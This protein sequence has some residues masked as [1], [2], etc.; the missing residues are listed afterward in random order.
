MPSIQP[1]VHPKTSGELTAS[2]CLHGIATALAIRLA[3]EI[4]YKAALYAAALT[5]LSLSLI[6]RRWVVEDSPPPPPPPTLPTITPVDLA[7]LDRF[8]KE[9]QPHTKPT[10]QK[11]PGEELAKLFAEMKG[12]SSDSEHDWKG[13]LQKVTGHLRTFMD[14]MRRM[15]TIEEPLLCR[16][17]IMQYGYLRGAW[18]DYKAISTVPQVTTY[19]NWLAMN[20][21]ANLSQ[22]FEFLCAKW[23]AD[24]R[25]AWWIL[26]M[27]EN[28]APAEAAPLFEYLSWSLRT[29]YATLSEE[30]KRNLGEIFKYAHQNWQLDPSGSEALQKAQEAYFKLL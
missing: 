7:T 26:G 22:Y 15:P 24:C 13:H 21:W 6:A 2:L 8:S 4:P 3:Q 27:W 11:M 1:I 16:Q 23:D 12:W 17:L 10:I 5:P 14:E 29:E 9:V 19:N 30:R 28:S 25:L 20:K 18:E